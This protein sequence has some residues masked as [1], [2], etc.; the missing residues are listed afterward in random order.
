MTVVLWILGVLFALIVLLCIA[1]MAV[2]VV[3]RPDC[4]K[5]RVSLG[6]LHKTLW[7]DRSPTPRQQRRA[8]RR[9]EKE[10]RRT[11]KEKKKP[12][13]D[14]PEKKVK[15]EKSKRKLTLEQILLLVKAALQA[16]G[17]LIKAIHVPILSLDVVVG[18][19]DPAD[20][21]TKFG[22]VNAIWYSLYPFA[23]RCGVKPRAVRFHLNF[24]ALKCSAQGEVKVT[25]R[26]G[27]VLMIG[28]RLLL[29]YFKVRKLSD[30]KGNEIKER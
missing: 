18:D 2:H 28:L 20:A 7:F 11:E 12:R 24:D 25:L 27:A 21:A 5:V 4:K 30:N 26:V 16:A 1:R 6:V 8:A 10:R 22:R 17:R 15:K 23:Y 14:K 19:S 3:W 29:K 9:A 13:K